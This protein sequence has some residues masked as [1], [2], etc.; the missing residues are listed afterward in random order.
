MMGPSI[1]H[2]RR[3]HDPSMIGEEVLTAVVLL[4]AGFVLVMV[5]GDLLSK[6]GPSGDY[7]Y[8]WSYRGNGGLDAI[9]LFPLTVLA[10]GCMIAV[11]VRG[12]SYGTGLVAGLVAFVLG[13]ATI[14]GTSVGVVGQLP[15][16]ADT[17]LLYGVV[18][19]VSL[20][21]LGLGAGLGL[22]WRH[23]RHTRWAAAFGALAAVAALFAGVQLAAD[24]NWTGTSALL[25]QIVLVTLI[26]VIPLL[27][28][29]PRRALRHSRRAHTPTLST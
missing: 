1:K 25:V 19:A 23:V 20:A 28:G 18:A 11:W 5:V 27:A 15:N 29:G 26:P 14:V 4:F 6:Y 12:F 21:V 22:A 7:P 3:R 9:I 16:S 17:R 13:A 24:D 8:S 2:S 10:V